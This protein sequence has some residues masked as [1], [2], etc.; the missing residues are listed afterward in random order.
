[1]V[2]EGSRRLWQAV[3]IHG[4]REALSG[5]DRSW[6][7]SQD[8]SEVC[9]LAG[10][11]PEVMSDWIDAVPAQLLAKRMDHAHKTSYSTEQRAA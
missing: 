2:A 1:M 4:I 6:L 7:Y 10:Y 5:R 8:Y 9:R 11:D 3:L